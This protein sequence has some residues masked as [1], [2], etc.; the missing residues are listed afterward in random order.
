MFK[1]ITHNLDQDDSKRF[2]TPIRTKQE[3]QFFVDWSNETWADTLDDI[4]L[5][6]TFAK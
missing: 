6:V 4:E 2:N 1:R 5:F 3:N